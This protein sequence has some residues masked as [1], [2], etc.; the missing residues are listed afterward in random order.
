MVL[1]S[2]LIIDRD[3]FIARNPEGARL[4]IYRERDRAGHETTQDCTARW[5]LHGLFS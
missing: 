2:W 4:W 3:Y 1:K 5:F